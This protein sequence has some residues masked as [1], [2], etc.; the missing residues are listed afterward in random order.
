MTRQKLT[1]SERTD[2]LAPSEPLNQAA[3]EARPKPAKMTPDEQRRRFIEAAR[4]A[5][6]SEDEAEF[7]RT[8][9]QILSKVPGRG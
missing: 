2:S 9:G 1:G 4:E 8:L 3:R 6:A 5:G 7:D